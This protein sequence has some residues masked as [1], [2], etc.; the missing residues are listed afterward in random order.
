[1]TAKIDDI[2]PETL[3]EFSKFGYYS[4][5]FLIAA[6]TILLPEVLNMTFMIYGGIVPSIKQC[7][8]KDFTNLTKI[9]ACNLIESVQNETGC[10]P[11]LKADFQSLGYEVIYFKT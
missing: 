1:M 3:G 6:E 10:K 9:E 4:I 2:K 11:V 5:F 8:Q 7:G